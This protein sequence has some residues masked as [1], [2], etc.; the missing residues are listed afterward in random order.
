MTALPPDCDSDPDRWWS[1]ESPQDVHEMIGPELRGPALDVGCGEGWLATLDPSVT[2]IGLDTSPT[3]LTANLDGAVVLADMRALP[4]GDET[5]AELTHLWCLYHV[6]DPSVA[7]SEARRVLRSAGHYYAST[8]V[9]DN[10]GAWPDPLRFG[11]PA[12][13]GRGNDAG[14]LSRFHRSMGSTV[15]TAR[16]SPS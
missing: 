3:Q 7:L 12:S 16:L 14:K 13:T 9:R 1:W 15:R 4:F 6:E 2:W 5:F 10:A 11:A 8:A